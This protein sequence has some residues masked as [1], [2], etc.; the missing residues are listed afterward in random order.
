MLTFDVLTLAGGQLQPVAT[1]REANGAMRTANLCAPITPPKANDPGATL[2]FDLLKVQHGQW[3]PVAKYREANGVTHVT[4]LGDPITPHQDPRD[5]AAAVM[6]GVAAELA[7]LERL[8]KHRGGINW[9][10]GCR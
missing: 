9:L 10:Q 5:T 1:Y 8:Y 2:A 3:Q 4:P 7:R 6:A